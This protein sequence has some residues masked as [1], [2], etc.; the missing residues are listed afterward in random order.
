MKRGRG[1]VCFDR[2]SESRKLKAKVRK[3]H[4][5]QNNTVC[6]LSQNVSLFVFKAVLDLLTARHNGLNGR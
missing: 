1:E 5:C 4:C 3:M 6:F 2:L